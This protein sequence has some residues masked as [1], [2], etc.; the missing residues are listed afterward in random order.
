[1]I[2]G[3]SANFGVFSVRGGFVPDPRT[4][5]VTSGGS[6]DVSRF[7]LAPGCRGFVTS[8]PDVIVH[9]AAPARWIR[10]FV[11]GAGD[12]TLVV[13]D[14]AGRWHCDDDSGG[15]L[16]PMLEISNPPGGQYD[17]WIG[18]YRASENI[19]GTLHM[20]ELSSVRP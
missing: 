20:T 3:S 5:D 9:Y 4:F 17:I 16:N 19:R 8:T 6:H 2:G 14:G 1:M 11:R 18:S 13:N 15:S 7:T 12:T 10:F